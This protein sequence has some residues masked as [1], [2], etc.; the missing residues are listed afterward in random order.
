MVDMLDEAELAEGKGGSACAVKGVM[1]LWG[2]KG[3][4][5]RHNNLQDTCKFTKYVMKGGFCVLHTKTY[6]SD[7]IT[8]A[9]NL[10]HWKL[11][12]VF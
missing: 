4:Q 10:L 9:P 7:D 3:E 5:I 11:F 12:L 8:T 6:V 2:G 1:Q